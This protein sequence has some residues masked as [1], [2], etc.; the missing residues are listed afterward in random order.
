MARAGHSSRIHPS[1]ERAPGKAD[2]WVERVGG[3]PSYIDRIARHLH[4]D[5]GMTISRAIASAVSQVRRWSRG[6]GDVK[7]DTR[8]K[9]LAAVAS[10]ESKKARSKATT[11]TRR[12]GPGRGRSRRTDLS[13]R[14]TSIGTRRSTRTGTS[15]FPRQSTRRCTTT[16]RV[17]PFTPHGAPVDLATISSH[18]WV[19]NNP[20]TALK[21]RKGAWTPPGGGASISAADIRSRLGAKTNKD[22]IR[23]MQSDP[24]AMDKVTGKGVTRSRV[25]NRPRKPRQ[26]TD[27]PGTQVRRPGRTRPVED[28]QTGDLI[29]T[30]GGNPVMV[31]R[32]TP[33]RIVNEDGSNP[34]Q[35]RRL[36]VVP[37]QGPPRIR[38]DRYGRTDPNERP[39]TLVAEPGEEFNVVGRIKAGDQPGFGGFTRPSDQANRRLS[40]TA[41]MRGR[42]GGGSTAPS[43]PSPSSGPS[44]SRP[45]VE[46]RPVRNR[47]SRTQGDTPSGRA[48]QD[49]NHRSRA[50]TL[51]Q[52]RRNA[53]ERGGTGYAMLSRSTRTSPNGRL[54]VDLLDSHGD[55]WSVELE[56]T[57]GTRGVNNGVMWVDGPDGKTGSA[58]FQSS[59][60]S[61]QMKDVNALID[62]VRAGKRRQVR[63]GRTKAEADKIRT[64]D[65]KRSAKYAHLNAGQK[66]GLTKARKH[67]REQG[68]GK[69]LGVGIT[70][71][72][73]K[74]DG[75]RMTAE[76]VDT[77][78]AVYQIDADRSVG[79]YTLRTADGQTL[80][81]DF[82]RALDYTDVA[83]RITQGGF[84]P[85][86]PAT[87]ATPRRRD[88]TTPRRQNNAGTSRQ[89]SGASEGALFGLTPAQK[90]DQKQRILNAID[91]FAPGTATGAATKLSRGEPVTRRVRDGDDVMEMT[92]QRD[93][94]GRGWSFTTKAPDERDNVTRTGL[95]LPDAIAGARQEYREIFDEELPR[96]TKNSRN[97]KPAE[98]KMSETEIRQRTAHKREQFNKRWDSPEAKAARMREQIRRDEEHRAITFTD[99]T[100]KA[101][102]EAVEANRAAGVPPTSNR[103]VRAAEYEHRMALRNFDSHLGKGTT[104]Q[105]RERLKRAVTA[106]ENATLDY[107]TRE[108]LPLQPPAFAKTTRS[109]ATSA[110]ARYKRDQRP[111]YMVS[112]GDGVRISN[113]KPPDNT[114][115]ASYTGGDSW[116]VHEPRSMARRV[117]G[118]PSISSIRPPGGARMHTN[119]G[120]SYRDAESR[121]GGG[122]ISYGADGRWSVTSDR[123]TDRDNPFYLEVTPDGQWRRHRD[124][125]VEN[126]NG[127]PDTPGISKPRGWVSPSERE[128]MQ[129]TPEQRAAAA[130]SHD[131]Q[132]RAEAPARAQESYVFQNF[133]L[134]ASDFK[135]ANTPITGMNRVGDRAFSELVQGN[136]EK[137]LNTLREAA[138]DIRTGDYPGNDR[139]FAD[140]LDKVADK[141]EKKLRK[142]KNVGAALMPLERGSR[143][144][145]GTV[146]RRAVDQTGR[147]WDLMLNPNEGTVRA[148]SGRLSGEA[149]F[150]KGD[151]QAATLAA[152]HLVGE[153]IGTRPQGRERRVRTDP[154]TGQPNVSDW[155]AREADRSE[156]NR[157]QAEFR[158]LRALDDTGQADDDKA[159]AMVAARNNAEN[160]HAVVHGAGI[161]P[162]TQ[163]TNDKGRITAGLMDSQ[164]GEWSIEYDRAAGVFWVD[165]PGGRSGSARIGRG[166]DLSMASVSELVSDLLEGKRRGVRNVT[167]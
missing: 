100:P 143:A 60:Q 118:A 3:L 73:G 65:A 87:P 98:P 37:P 62:D 83:K 26:D 67:K 47:P 21:W 105:A 86:R 78:G 156:F 50:E 23:I 22:A 80:T 133:N 77:N 111:V 84:S 88:T 11:A 116:G 113:V 145:D 19:P 135:D 32:S 124:G 48:P 140:R 123:P 76:L 39:Q 132:A 148:T 20:I 137:A 110:R 131:E 9:A 43:S 94:N 66:K 52:A 14:Y 93:P 136:P 96:A 35:G 92:I 120:D 44:P 90:R 159:T 138:N 104:E 5:Q 107:H 82:H 71:G 152:Q 24:A 45:G 58:R 125:K 81:G 121:P 162:N 99:P 153:M 149:T 106:Y 163:S 117:S 112:E 64:Q 165:G 103:E 1:L 15:I 128:R 4:Y 157:R 28:I 46:S 7:P 74:R 17:E 129:P 30:H 6:G 155:N 126:L 41:S 18:G 144:S 91:G 12:R 139:K 61:P 27:W 75:E 95:S 31:A 109:G 130:R 68:G 141:V 167:R 42:R 63:A 79:R 69:A 102:R 115:Y 49:P 33:E 101:I 34:R 114:R 53:Q 25:A 38:G 8:A 13:T 16:W 89:P 119:V 29:E 70:E 164:G 160:Y 134:N 54:A 51:A 161:I 55:Q 151:Q 56:S 166:L 36:A 150:K 158:R 127:S 10:W 85:D 59:G 154:T 2:N 146:T 72:S 40:A 147:E 142:P 122:F 57:P 108:A 97:A